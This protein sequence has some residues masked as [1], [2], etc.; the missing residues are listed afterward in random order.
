MRMSATCFLNKRFSWSA[1]ASTALACALASA[2]CPSA[3]STSLIS[4]LAF[5]IIS[6][7][8][9]A[10]SESC[11]CASCVSSSKRLARCSAASAR[12]LDCRISS[13]SRFPSAS[14]SWTLLSSSRRFFTACSTDVFADSATPVATLASVVASRSLP[15]AMAKSSAEASLLRMIHATAAALVCAT[16]RAAIASIS[17][18][19]SSMAECMLPYMSLRTTSASPAARSARCLKRSWSDW[20]CASCDS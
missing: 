4:T 9:A 17:R 5:S 20:A 19:C 11:V 10:A 13:C 2:V 7:L 6:F 18:S 16:L 12:A 3:L 15:L 14:N 8:S 1:A